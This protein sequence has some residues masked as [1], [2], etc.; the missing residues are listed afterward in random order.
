MSSLLV[1]P[2][3][4]DALLATSET[5]LV[6]AM[7]DFSALPYSDGSRDF[8]AGDPYLS[9]S[10]LSKPFQNDNLHLR[11]GLHLHW[12]LP[13]TL[14]K[15]VHTPDETNPGQAAA[16]F[17]RVPNRWLITRRA[18]LD[19]SIEAQWVVESDYLYPDAAGALTPAVTILYPSDP[20]AGDHR[21]FRYL[22]RSLRID[23]WNP[24]DPN[25]EYLERLTAIGYGTPLFAAL[26]AN[27][28]SVFGFHDPDLNQAQ[29]SDVYYELIGWYSDA[30]Q[31]FL[32]TFIADFQTRYSAANAGQAPNDDEIMAEIAAELSWQVAKGAGD[33]LPSNMLCYGRL[34]FAPDPGGIDNALLDS[35]PTLAFG[36]T[37]SEAISAWLG[38]AVD[39]ANA[40]LIEDQMEALQL[41]SQLEGRQLDLGSSFTEARH[42][43]GFNAVTGGTLWT[44]RPRSS[45]TQASAVDGAAQM[46]IELPPGLADRLNTLNLTQQR[47]D[48]ALAEIEARRRQLYAD[49]CRFM[50]CSYPPETLP[51]SYPDPDEVQLFIEERG[52]ENLRRQEEATGTLLLQY[53]AG[54]VVTSAS[55]GASASASL[56]A[57]LAQAVNDALSDLASHNSSAEVQ[58]ANVSLE[59]QPGPGP[60]YWQPAEPGIALAGPAVAPSRRHGNTAGDDSLCCPVI[61][62]PALSYPPVPAQLN[63]LLAA[64]A[65]L[66]DSNCSAG[67]IAFSAAGH[68]TWSVQPWHPLLLEWEVEVFPLANKSNVAD[69]NRN[70]GSD[71]VSDNYV[72]VENEPDLTLQAGKGQVVKAAN[73]YSGQSM[74]TPLPA[75]YLQDT[76]LSW[77]NKQL[78]PQYYDANPGVTPDDDYLQAPANLAAVT[79]WYSSLPTFPVAPADQAADPLYSALRALVPLLSDEMQAQALSGF[80]D[81]LLM[82]QQ[83]LQ[84]DIAD[85]LR[86]DQEL[87]ASDFMDAVKAAV[88]NFNRVSPQPLN[89]FNPIRSGWLRL[90]RA[91]L[92]DSFGQTLE[93]DVDSVV[94][95]APLLLPGH[96]SMLRLNPRFVPPL[97]LNMRWLAAADD[98]VEMN[99]HPASSPVCGWLLSNRLDRSLMVYDQQGGALGSIEGNAR[100]APAPGSAAAATID[101]VGNNHLRRLL[102]Y[103]AYDPA[104]ADPVEEAE[105]QSFLEAFISSIDSAL[106]RIDPE[107]FAE[108]P[109]LALLI[110]RPIALT[111]LTLSM[112]MLGLPPLHQGWDQFRHDLA[113]TIRETNSCAAVSLPLRLGEYG[114]YNDGVVGYWIEQADGFADNT[115]YTPQSDV[116]HVN[117]RSHV[118]DPFH[119]NS[120]IEAPPLY[121]TMLLDPRG[122]AHA[123]AGVVPVKSIAIPPDQYYAALQ[124]LQVTFQTR[125]ILTPADNIAL[126][127]PAEAGYSWSWLDRQNGAWIATPEQPA[128]ADTAAAFSASLLLREGWLQLTPDE[129]SP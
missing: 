64:V 85:P 99:A 45:T 21:P 8:N 25:A 53:D 28:H 83:V 81:A 128:A 19:D 91:R 110:G 88:K 104:S 55:A 54:G 65:A 11:P 46:N 60:R 17:P 78:L 120:G 105:K 42:A 72:S 29:L 31:D 71:F 129:E 5:T 107:N 6:D 4:L 112:E 89:D 18:S 96:P 69:S 90:S 80:N 48:R 26:Y 77:L 87:S 123:S 118:D 113:R 30:A 20:A 43:K 33:A 39:P 3:R 70:Y 108:Q 27:C 125:P 52:L 2:L 93:L 62:D 16:V 95:A 37:S 74:L 66:D 7:A 82:Q 115:Y 36:N 15:G 35:S 14:A 47:Y 75:R 24:A 49:W 97:R 117:I 84:L 41:G 100:W 1:V 50:T 121:L 34:D 61:D 13:D 127:L 73:L 63:D 10:V 44:L 119:L 92:L 68:R 51:D 102:R 58:A 116:Q 23:Q 40:A 76:L 114:K 79:A 101:E 126:P 57:V 109:D 86:F 12:A 67:S 32:A 59:L 94:R 124:A 22:G 56:A 122:L 9:T 103:L 111:R 106:A 98:V 38:N